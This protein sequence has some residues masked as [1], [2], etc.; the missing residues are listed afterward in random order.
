MQVLIIAGKDCENCRHGNVIE[1]SKKLIKVY[2]TI[3][4][5]EYYYGQCIPC[6]NKSK[7]V[8]EKKETEQNAE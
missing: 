8:E 4:D 2:C 1:H 3:K 7:I 5:K 6:E